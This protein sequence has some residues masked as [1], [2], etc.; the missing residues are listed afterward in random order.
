MITS[1][2]GDGWKY[3]F[4]SGRMNMLL[5]DCACNV[6]ISFDYRIPTSI[7]WM[8]HVKFSF[9]SGTFGG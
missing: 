3:Q 8:L 4:F 9:F 5:C 1:V 6:M 7:S 2:Y